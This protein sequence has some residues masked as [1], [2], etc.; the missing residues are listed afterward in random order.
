MYSN[1]DNSNDDR[2]TNVGGLSPH[3]NIHTYST[4]VL[5]FWL[6]VP[7]S[8]FS[9]FSFFFHLCSL[10]ILIDLKKINGLV[11]NIRT[12]DPFFPAC[13]GSGCKYLHP[14][15]TL[16]KSRNASVCWWHT[17][18]AGFSK[19]MFDINVL[20]EG[21]LSE[22]WPQKRCNHLYTQTNEGVYFKMNGVFIYI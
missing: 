5:F 19:L 6:S 13:I 20:N 1:C 2:C 14:S 4:H 21:H 22:K 8:R 9:V 10:L 17:F 11:K 7:F 16:F 3:V 15:A 18:K 12:H